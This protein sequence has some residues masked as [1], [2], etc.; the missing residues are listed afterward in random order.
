[1]TR[2]IHAFLNSVKE[3]CYILNVQSC[4]SYSNLIALIL[5]GSESIGTF[6]TWWNG[7]KP[8]VMTRVMHAFLNSLK[9]ICAIM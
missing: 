4:E 9:G 1:M 2:V 6:I 5:G 7:V 3:V 8:W